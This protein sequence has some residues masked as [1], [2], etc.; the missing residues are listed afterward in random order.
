VAVDA[1]HLEPH[2]KLAHNAAYI[3]GAM[4]CH[5]FDT[6]RYSGRKESTPSANMHMPC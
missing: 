4:L 2:S 3:A 1:A 6:S 5:G